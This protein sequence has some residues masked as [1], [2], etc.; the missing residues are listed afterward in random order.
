MHRIFFSPI[1]I[2]ISIF[3]FILTF[4]TIQY[5]KLLKKT[6]YGKEHPDEHI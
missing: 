5:N 1:M 3:L 6:R 4:P 2:G